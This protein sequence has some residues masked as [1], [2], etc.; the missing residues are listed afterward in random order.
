MVV[1]TALARFI[2]D[3]K[4]D[5]PAEA[6]ELIQEHADLEAVLFCRARL[7][8]HLLSMKK[9]IHTESHKVCL[10]RLGDI[11]GID[12][13]IDDRDLWTSVWR[14]LIADVTGGD[15]TGE[16]AMRID[17]IKEMLNPD[18]YHQHPATKETAATGDKSAGSLVANKKRVVPL[19]TFLKDFDVLLRE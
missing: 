15:V 3:G 17:Q 12:A 7:C 4:A 8:L 10:D 1:T 18:E 5:L 13:R 9:V 19:P 14:W 11:C 2:A 6:L 16:I